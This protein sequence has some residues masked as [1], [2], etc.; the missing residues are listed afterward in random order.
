MT[1]HN[2]TEADLDRLAEKVIERMDGHTWV[3]REQHY[4]DHRWVQKRRSQEG[5][6]VSERRSQ[7][8]PAGCNLRG[9]L[10]QRF[11][12]YCGRQSGLGR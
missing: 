12:W 9:K 7:R 1:V 3:D 5:A 11:F 10:Q 8:E 6:S 4:N 2:M